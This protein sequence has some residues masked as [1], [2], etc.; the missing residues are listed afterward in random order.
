MLIRIVRMTFQEN[1]VEA[2]LHLFEA[3]KRQIRQYP[4]CQRLELLRDADQPAVF[5]TYSWWIDEQALEN[6][7]VSPLFK[8]TW[9]KT[10][11][12]FADKPRAFSS[13]KFTE[14]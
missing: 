3:T 12:L 11:V 6:Y 9:A 5:M 4:G 2:F 13:Y 8:E 1:K 7:R 14:A 10:K